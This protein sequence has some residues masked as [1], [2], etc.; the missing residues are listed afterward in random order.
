MGSG[1]SGDR[2]R[3]AART[4]RLAKE[5][6]MSDEKTV[7]EQD[8]KAVSEETA[9]P[10]DAQDDDLDSLLKEFESG[11]ETRSETKDGDQEDALAT[12]VQSLEARLAQQDF[13]AVVSN[14]RGDLDVDP[15]FVEGWLEA[16]ARKSTSLATAYANRRNDPQKWAKVEAKLNKELVG[17]FPRV[18]KEAT[19]V[20]DT[21]TS[22]VRSA[23]TRTA[24]SDDDTPADI[25]TWPQ[26]KFEA[27]V[28]EQGRKHG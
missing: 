23:S 26:H 10:E 17:M 18:D 7:V 11:S 20:H 15:D 14:V 4:G 12:K 5:K 9:K 22:S 16:R 2:E 3:D 24:E 25:G 19:E 21:I 28:K 1:P 8:D 6:Q 13:Q 27:W